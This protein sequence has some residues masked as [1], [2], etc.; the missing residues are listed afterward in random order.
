MQNFSQILQTFQASGKQQLNH[1]QVI[2]NKILNNDTGCLLISVPC[3]GINNL[4]ILW[5]LRAEILITETEKVY[6]F[7]LMMRQVKKLSSYQ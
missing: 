1:P 5:F 6:K 4:I 7:I 2:N 3:L